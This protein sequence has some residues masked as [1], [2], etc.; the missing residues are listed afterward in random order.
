MLFK[1]Q[2]ELIANGQTPS[3]RKKRRDVLTILDAAVRSVD[4]YNAVSSKI[5]KNRICHGSTLIRIDDFQKVFLVGFGKASVG[6]AQAVCDKI[7][8]AKGVIITNDLSVKVNHP[9]IVTIYGGHPIPDENSIEGTK[10]IEKLIAD[11]TYDDLVIVVI[12]GGG[13]ALLCHPRVSLDDMQKTTML[14]LRSG[15]TIAEINTVRKH[16]SYVK[17]GNLFRRSTCHVV[18]FIISDVIDDPLESI[19]SGPTCGDDSTY[20]DAS[21]IL[22]KYHLWDAITG[23][24]RDVITDG[25]NSLIPETPSHNDDMFKNISN[26]IVANNLLACK[27]AFDKAT[28]LGYR[29]MILSTSV[30]GEASYVGN[31]LL[32]RS[33]ILFQKGQ[34]TLCIAGGETTVNV[35]GDGVGGRNQEMVLSVVENLATTE[36]VFVSFATDGLDGVSP[37]AG[38][39]ADGLTFERSK[40]CDMGPSKYLFEHDSYSFF[41]RLNDVLLTGPTGTNV[42]DIQMVLL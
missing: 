42:M 2:A 35:C 13:S 17:G 10:A 14:L 39:I 21:I 20:Q 12:S 7:H 8:V 23:S 41:S 25:M 30:G 4:P 27:A 32:E 40:N 28:E 3:L 38:A 31:D 29:P 36:Q 5:I 11:C 34:I 19:A 15:A 33:R 37:S 18:S 26:I 6:M 1:N 22:R 16:L 24:V 9:D